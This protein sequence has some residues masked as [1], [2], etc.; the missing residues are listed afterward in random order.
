MLRIIHISDFHLN[1]KN[2]KDWNDYIKPAFLEKLDELNKE[3]II[4]FIAC[5]GDLIDKGGNSFPNIS[6]AF[7][8]FE[9]YVINPIIEKI[10]FGR[11]QFLF[12]PG[13]HDI[14]RNADK[15]PI[16]LGYKSYFQ[17]DYDN[18]SNFMLTALNKDEREGLRR[19][20]PFKEF[21]KKFYTDCD[22]CDMTVFGSSFILKN[23]EES[24]G[25][26]CLNSAWRAYYENDKDNLIVGEEQLKKN[27]S[28]IA[29]CDIKIG[30][31]HHPID[32]LIPTE[33]K[34]IASH[35]TKDFDILLIGHVHENQTTYQIGFTGSLFINIAPAY[36]NDIR[37][38]SKAFG[39]GF[40]LICYDKQNR[41]LKCEYYKFDLVQR[42]FILNTEEGDEGIFLSEI[43]NK[44]TS[45]EIK[46]IQRLLDNIRSEHYESMNSHLI[47][48]K[49]NKNGNKTT[50]KECFIFPPIDEG[51][52]ADSEEGIKNFNLTEIVKSNQNLVFFGGQ[53]VG[54]TT[55]LYR[56][57]NEYVEDYEHL[58]KLP[59]YLNL[60][61]IG[62]KEIIASIKEYIRCN[63]EEVNQLLN[64]NSIILLVDN[65][66]FS[67]ESTNHPSNK[68]HR[69]NEQYEE[70]QI[71][72]TGMSNLTG[73]APVDFINI[74]NIP[75]KKYFINNLQ[76]K[77]VKSLIKLWM[78]NV[79]TQNA[80]SRLQK[81]VKDF[82]S[83]SLP[84]TAMS[85]SLFLWSTES[86]D[87]KPINNAVLLDIY[88]EL[89]LEKLTE[90][91]IYRDTFD[92]RNKCLLIASIAQEMLL[93]DDNNYCISYSEYI[94]VVEDYLKNKVGFSYDAE[95]IAE[96]FIERKIFS[97]YDSNK[98]KFSKT[99][100]FHFFIAK[101]MEY[102][103]DFKD[104]VLQEENYF[105]FQKEIDYYSGLVRNDEDL[106]KLIFERF[107]DRF[108]AT[109]FIMEQINID[110]YFTLSELKEHKHLTDK[111][112]ISDIQK[113]RPD[114]EK[115]EEI[116]N[117]QLSQI[118]NPYDILK[119]NGEMSLE[120]LI[121][122]M[123]N[124]LRNSEGVENLKLKKDAYN[125]IIKYSITWVVLYRELLL[126]NL[127]ERKENLPEHLKKYSY[128]YLFK[129]LPFHVQLG[130][131]EQL[132][133]YKLSPIIL[134]KIKLDINE[135]KSDIE[136]FYSVALYSDIQGQ[137][138]DKLLKKYIKSIDKK[139]IS[140]D[141]IFRKIIDYYYL[142][143]RVG[144]DNEIMY[145][146]L[147]WEIKMRRN[148]LPKKMKEILISTF[149][150]NRTKY[151]LD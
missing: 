68:L 81:L 58:H 85:V 19:I 79:E 141:Y 1:T 24:I 71:I 87:R 126:K 151:S 40:S 41:Q 122:I 8:S 106:L 54:K 140:I 50:L 34:I 131:N 33:R 88:I 4:S 143:T 32:W 116:Y 55:L 10:T 12:I 132:G 150:D 138:F 57:V 80:E 86:H 127:I 20:V 77:Q 2:L 73:V 102:N 56:L 128:E 114:E 15:E 69:F 16:E 7:E 9:S 149:R 18:I 144:S 75:F 11:K 46:L 62:N 5:T 118:K 22:D 135:K 51:N 82:N 145:L 100:F 133:T 121:I 112:E 130:L 6:N 45:K 63:T 97:K 76:T 60:E 94:R 36:I 113:N 111:V 48:Q 89:I 78:P 92:Y 137:N 146:D 110:D 42:K 125:S 129:Y 104:Y 139:K 95:K 96:Y 120:Q 105:K 66:K 39:N 52:Y 23:G 99:C 119:K 117:K 142:R 65:L 38:E 59:V 29:N 108:E 101:R 21:E 3:N 53:E 134:D 123:S 83:Y 25:I 72:A 93:K 124:V 84:C 47:N 147:L 13:N 17:K 67:K 115:L 148:K 74:C 27:Y 30:L 43:P 90:N 26:A 49:A 109:D 35:I 14:D 107:K 28:Y 103:K 44:S 31:I 70:I 91:N 64:N 98:V 136:S 37:T 61:E